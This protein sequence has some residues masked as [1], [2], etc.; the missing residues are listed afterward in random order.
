MAFNR[1]SLTF[2]ASELAITHFD[3]SRGKVLS[4]GIAAFCAGLACS[5]SVVE[6]CGTQRGF[7][8]LESN[9]YFLGILEKQDYWLFSSGKKGPIVARGALPQ[10]FFSSAKEV[11]I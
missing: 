5:F 11:S 1:E 4:K 3:P 6:I 7:L 8:E 9:K 10:Q 2:Y